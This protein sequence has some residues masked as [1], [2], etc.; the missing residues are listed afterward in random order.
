[1]LETS[2]LKAYIRFW[3]VLEMSPSRIGLSGIIGSTLK[4]HGRILTLDMLKR[5]GRILANRCFLCEEM[6]ESV[7]HLLLHCS[8]ARLLWDLLLAIVGVNWVFSL[9][10]REALLSWSGSF[11]GKKCKIALM[12]APLVI[13]WTI[14][15]ERN[16]IVFDNIV[17]SAQRMKSSFL[18]NFWSWT[19][20]YIMDKP[21]SL[22]GCR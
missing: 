17:F 8:K 16:N 15:R 22:M 1:M 7:D 21:S 10:V 18:Y 12:A 20:L 9:T 5:R 6:D 11:V 14:W 4:R 13:F 2:W 19:Y 3:T